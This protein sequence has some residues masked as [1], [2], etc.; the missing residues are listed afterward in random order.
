MIQPANSKHLAS[1]QRSSLCFKCGQKRNL[2]RA[3]S[4]AITHGPNILSQHPLPSITRPVTSAWPLVSA[5]TFRSGHRAYRFNEPR[6]RWFPWNPYLDA[7]T[8]TTQATTSMDFL[9]PSPERQSAPFD[10][11][12]GINTILVETTWIYAF[13]FSSETTII[14]HA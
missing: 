12:C 8:K 14:Y 9:I 13:T 6:D 11:T 5:N 7:G 1:P 2:S 3:G 4:N 10:D